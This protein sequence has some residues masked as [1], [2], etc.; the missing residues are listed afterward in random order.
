[1]KS[2]WEINS[3]TIFITKPTFWVSFIC[4]DIVSALGLELRKLSTAIFW[5]KSYLNCKMHT[6]YVE[7]FVPILLLIFLNSGFSPSFYLFCFFRGFLYFILSE[8]ILLFKLSFLYTYSIVFSRY[9]CLHYFWKSFRL[10]QDL[11][12]TTN[13]SAHEK[14]QTINI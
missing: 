7:T 14:I 9:F 5:S 13:P 10:T 12:H 1:M 6:V 4:Q 8:F 11:F 3:L 2:N